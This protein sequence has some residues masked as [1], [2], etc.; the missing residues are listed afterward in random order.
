MDV[1]DVQVSDKDGCESRNNT[2]KA[3]NKIVKER[4]W[5]L[6]SHFATKIVLQHLAPDTDAQLHKERVISCKKK[7]NL[8]LEFCKRNVP[9]WN[10]DTPETSCQCDEEEFQEEIIVAQNCRDSTCAEMRTNDPDDDSQQG[11]EHADGRPQADRSSVARH[12]VADLVPSTD[13]F[14]E[15]KGSMKSSTQQG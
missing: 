1:S 15:K 5:T 13:E 7:P 3:N 2:I 6:D 12:D 4:I 14:E 10:A 8:H 9:K 11:P